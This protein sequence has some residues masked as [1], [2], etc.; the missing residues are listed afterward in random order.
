VALERPQLGPVHGNR[1][2]GRGAWCRGAMRQIN[3]GG[4]APVSG[5]QSGA[6]WRHRGGFSAAL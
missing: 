3:G 4:S 1:W 2:H 5:A 6:P